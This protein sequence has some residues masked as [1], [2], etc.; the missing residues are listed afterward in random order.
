VI[1]FLIRAGIFLASA[2]IGLIVASLVVTAFHITWGD[3]WGFVLAV[4][5]FAIVQSV[6]APIATRLAKKRAPILL[7]GVGILATFVSITIVVLIPRAGMGIST[8]GGWLLAPLVVWV[9]SALV[10][11]GLSAL[12][13]TKPAAEKA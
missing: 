8:P 11:W 12:L 10:T 6:I 5:I 13:L 1:T 2:A 7:G 9:V 4:V 3:W